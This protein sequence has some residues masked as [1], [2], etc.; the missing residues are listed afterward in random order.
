MRARPSSCPDSAIARRIRRRL[1]RGVPVAL[2]VTAGVMSFSASATAAPAKKSPYTLITQAFTNAEHAG[3]V[4]EVTKGKQGGHTF[5]A[6]NDIG[7]SEGRQI[8]QSDAARAQVVLI[9]GVAYVEGN[10][11]GI[12]NYFGITNVH[13]KRLA[14]KWLSL[15][16]KDAE[17]S[18]ITTAVTLKSDFSELQVTG[19]YTAGRP[20]VVDHVRVIP[21]HGL[22]TGSQGADPSPV[23]V[24]VTA[25]GKTL[26]VEF[27]A[28]SAT[29]TQSTTWSD[30]GRPVTL[31][32][33]AHSQPVPNP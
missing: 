11:K 12:E 14:G 32:V 9:K 17:Y 4:H 30:W 25:T 31:T 20:T 27:T 29:A 7:T 6:D 13:P 10:A 28:S 15:T 8:I 23:I 3:W 18:T 16:S 33:P 5:S 19:P 24:Y 22:A 21:V 2:G 1:S 26:P